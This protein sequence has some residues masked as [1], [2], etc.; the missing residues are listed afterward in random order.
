MDT[1]WLFLTLVEKELEDCIRPEMS[2]EWR[3]LRS[4]DYVDSFTVDAVPNFAREHVV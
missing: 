3:R 1:D 2:A 4:N